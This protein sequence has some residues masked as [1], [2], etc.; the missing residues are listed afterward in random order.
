VAATSVGIVD[1]VMCL[2][3]DYPEDSVA[4]VD[5]NVVCDGAGR[6]IEVQGTGEKAPFAR[7]RLNDL[8]DL[9]GDGIER[10]LEI[11][12]QALATESGIYR[13]RG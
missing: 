8:L 6:F 2:D 10:L 9:A 12:R 7:E 5:M 13:D 11:Q 4:E 3:L 1:G